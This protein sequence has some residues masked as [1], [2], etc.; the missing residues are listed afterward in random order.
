MR[1]FL[2]ATL[3]ASLPLP[4]LAAPVAKRS[5]AAVET[6]HAPAKASPEA[7]KAAKQGA[8]EV[9]L[10]TKGNDISFDQAAV[11]VPFSEKV[12]LKFA[13][14]AAVGSEIQHNVAILAPGTL[15]AVLKE[16]QATEYDLEKIKKNKSVLAMTRALA[17]GDSDVVEFS[18]EKPGFYPYICLMPG[19]GDML[20][21]RGVLHVKAKK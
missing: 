16:L 11:E 1:I 10:S 18:P 15:D 5:Q 4:A 2:S 8:V 7:A 21:M 13:N 6:P 9:R 12:S 17:P 20:N 14:E 19:H 3:L